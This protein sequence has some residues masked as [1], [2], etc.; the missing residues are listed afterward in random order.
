VALLI[1]DTTEITYAVGIHEPIHPDMDVALRME[2]YAMSRCEYGCKIYKDP[3]S[4]VKVLAH[5][6]AY[7][8]TKTTPLA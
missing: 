1:D 6:R 4:D 5:S 7:G 3:R 8:C 2:E